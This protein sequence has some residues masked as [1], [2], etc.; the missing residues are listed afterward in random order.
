[1]DYGSRTVD[2]IVSGRRADAAC[3]LTEWQ[4]FSAQNDVIA[5]VLKV[6]R[7]L[8]SSSPLVDACLLEEHFC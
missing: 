6:W 8:E 4:H 2:K 7:D 5:T 3:A 1:M